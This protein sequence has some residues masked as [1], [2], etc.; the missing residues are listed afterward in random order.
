MKKIRNWNW[1]GFWCVLIFCSIG[2]LGNKN[3]PNI[4]SWL[5]TT[6]AFGVPFGLLIAYISRDHD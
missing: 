3:I 6:L 5:I 2:F 4:E 1:S